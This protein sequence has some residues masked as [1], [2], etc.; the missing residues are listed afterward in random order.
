MKTSQITEIKL[1]L[2][3]IVIQRD[4]FIKTDDLLREIDKIFHSI[5]KF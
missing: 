5:S 1:E 4:P 2:L 3:K